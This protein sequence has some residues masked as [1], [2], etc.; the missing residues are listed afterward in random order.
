MWCNPCIRIH[1]LWE[2]FSPLQSSWFDVGRIMFEFPVCSWYMGL[3]S[4]CN[5]SLRVSKMLRPPSRA[6]GPPRRGFCSAD[7]LH[8]KVRVPPLVYMWFE[9]KLLR[10]HNKPRSNRF[11][12]TIANC[13]KTR[14]YSGGTLAGVCNFASIPVG[15]VTPQK[16][17]LKNQRV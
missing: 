3:E 2:C 8:H 6:R 7:R 10:F 16:N 11:F 13:R 12:V 9:K 15:E 14:I 17:S 4:K 1:C 5:N